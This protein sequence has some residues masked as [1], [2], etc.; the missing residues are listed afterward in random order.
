MHSGVD[1]AKRPAGFSETGREVAGY[2]RRIRYLR[3]GKD[4]SY[5]RSFIRVE[6]RIYFVSFGRRSFFIARKRRV[7][8]E[9]EMCL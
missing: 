3:R 1:A 6:P 9:R 7:C 8:A 5:R 4:L 2:G